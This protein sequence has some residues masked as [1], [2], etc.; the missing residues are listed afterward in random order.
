[1]RS[2]AS[3]LLVRL[4]VPG[5]GGDAVAQPELAAVLG[6]N[7]LGLD[8]PPLTAPRAGEDR[9]TREPDPAGS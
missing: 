4:D 1:V 2:Y 3:R 6:E 7:V 8:V 9:L 5:H